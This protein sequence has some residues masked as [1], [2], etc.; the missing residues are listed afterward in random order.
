MDMLPDAA[1]RPKRGWFV[2]RE[3]DE[4]SAVH[5]QFHAWRSQEDFADPDRLEPTLD[6]K[7]QRNRLVPYTITHK[8]AVFFRQIDTLIE[9]GLAAGQE[10]KPEQDGS[11]S[12]V[13]IAWYCLRVL[14]DFVF[15][16][17]SDEARSLAQQSGPL[18]WPG[19]GRKRS[20]MQRLRKAV[21]N[22]RPI[23]P[24]TP[25]IQHSS[26]VAVRSDFERG[27]NVTAVASVTT[28]A[29]SLGKPNS[30]ANPGLHTKAAATRASKAG[31]H[32]QAP[33]APTRKDP[34][35]IIISSDPEVPDDAMEVDTA[36]E[37]EKPPVV[38]VVFDLHDFCKYSN[39]SDSCQHLNRTVTGQFTMSTCTSGHAWTST[40]QMSHMS[41]PGTTMLKHG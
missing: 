27:T 38:Q 7:D 35:H 32:S 37:P 3:T 41:S 17:A 29:T 14:E 16:L 39:T 19:L 18:R 12:R 9:E 24:I 1:I 33:R 31:G 28:K 22:G 13:E 2:S 26:V 15:P 25:P 36:A 6:L 21:L 8:T 5:N 34:V 20:P 10:G 4:T 40:S 23:I 30:T 11:S